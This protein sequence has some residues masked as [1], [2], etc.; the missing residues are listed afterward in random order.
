MVTG[1][2][3]QTAKA[4][5]LEC[6][7]LQS[8][9]EA[10]EPTIIEGQV[11][12]A[13]SEKAREEIAE[14]ITVMGRSSPNDKL[15]LVQALKK[16]GHVVAVTG[17][18]TNDA[19][20][21]HEADIG[22]SM[23][24]MGTEVAKESSDIIILDDNFTSVVKVV[25]WGRSVSAN[26]QKFIQF[27]LTVNV[28]AL[29]INVVAAVSSGDIP[30]NAVELLWVNLIMDTLGALALATELPTDH[31]MKRLPVGQRDLRNT[32]IPNCSLRH[33]G[34][35]PTGF[36]SCFTAEIPFS[37]CTKPLHYAAI[38]LPKTSANWYRKL[39]IPLSTC[40]TCYSPGR[41]EPKFATGETTTFLSALRNCAEIPLPAQ[42]FFYIPSPDNM[43]TTGACSPAVKEIFLLFVRVSASL[44]AAR[45]RSYD[46][47]LF[48]SD[49][50]YDTSDR[51][52]RR[53]LPAA[54]VTFPLPCASSAIPWL[55]DFVSFGDVPSCGAEV[56][57]F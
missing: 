34:E 40:G 46:D 52:L 44:V 16:K 23:G 25:R 15:L 54:K 7:I 35:S 43:T 30:L 31:L 27:Q 17:D 50:S 8:E 28:A 5:A 51:K 26:I 12:R 24:V 39:Q 55:F 18:G 38:C 19:P 47:F 2:N 41:L 53:K 11:F 9:E 6:R 29:V 42:E 36:P 22:L 21:L 4:I 37:L 32:S 14:K 3:L 49:G 20:A 13:Y 56:T 1:D 10:I 57:T 33:N 48:Q 45:L